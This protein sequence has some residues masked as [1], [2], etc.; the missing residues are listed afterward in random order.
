MNNKGA[1]LII[2]TNAYWFWKPIIYKYVYCV[3]YNNCVYK[4]GSF[5]DN[6]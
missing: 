6:Y 5:C 3:G 4:P 1:G 2:F